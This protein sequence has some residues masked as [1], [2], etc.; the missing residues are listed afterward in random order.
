MVD[1]R[2]MSSEL[3][4]GKSLRDAAGFFKKRGV[5]ML[6]PRDLPQAG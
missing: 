5:S 1:Q 4:T 6:T 3:P 2:A